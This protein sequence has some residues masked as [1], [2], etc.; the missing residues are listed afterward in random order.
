MKPIKTVFLCVFAVFHFLHAQPVS[1]SVTNNNLALVQE[2]RSLSLNGGINNITI[3]DLPDL[4]DPSSVYVSFDSETAKIFEQSYNFDLPNPQ[5]ILNYSIGK[6]IRL[7][8]PD[9]GNLQGK[10]LSADQKTLVVETAENEIRIISDYSGGQI[11]LDNT[12]LPEKNS[13]TRPSLEW[14][15][16]ADTKSTVEA[17][18]S[19]LT[20]GLTWQAEYSAILDDNENEMTLT[21][22]VVVNNNSGLSFNQ[23]NLLLLAGDIHRVAKPRRGPVNRGLMDLAMEKQTGAT[24]EAEDVFEY[25]SYQLGRKITLKNMREKQISLFP[26]L[27]TKISKSFNYNYQK[28]PKNISVVVSAKNT[29][30]NGLGF[31]LPMG[32]VRIYKEKGDQRLILGED[33]IGHIPPNENIDIEVGKAFDIKAE[34]TVTERTREGK[35]S[36]KNKIAIEFRNRKKDDIEI[37]ITEPIPQ[38]RDSRIV[39]SNYKVFRKIADRVEFMIPVKAGQSAILNYEILYT[40]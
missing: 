34:R 19:Y 39:S 6:E 2:V 4:I 27:N 36:E 30:D 38:H 11:I 3:S 13:I 5:K 21:S 33:N 18:L 15:I 32:R 12:S 31:P 28:D 7:V 29:N 26:L 8:H 10:L 25:H 17:K 24:F 35:N 37:L 23:V 40:W 1:L 9:F 20:G 14:L 22:W 16:D